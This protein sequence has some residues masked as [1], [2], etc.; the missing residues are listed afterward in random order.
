MQQTAAECA[1]KPAE[2]AAHVQIWLQVVQQHL[3][4]LQRKL[5]ILQHDSAAIAANKEE[6][7][8]HGCKCNPDYLRV[9][10]ASYS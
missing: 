4:V 10:S 7:P 1:A 2:S 3:Q 8:A 9:P 5:Q 6:E